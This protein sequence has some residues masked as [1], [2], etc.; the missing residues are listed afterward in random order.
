MV[1]SIDLLLATGGSVGAF[2][3]C[4]G[5]DLVAFTLFTFALLKASS[6]IIA[7]TFVLG[8]IRVGGI[9]VALGKVSF[10]Q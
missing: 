8:L 9:G 4:T 10:R 7:L 3:G 6:G 5:A 1:E 2:A